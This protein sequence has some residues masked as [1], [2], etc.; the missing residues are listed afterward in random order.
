MTPDAAERLEVERVSRYRVSG[1]RSAPHPDG[2]W[3]PWS[4]ANNLLHR[5]R[6]AESEVQRLRAEVEALVPLARLG[7][8]TLDVLIPG[9]DGHI[10]NTIDFDGGDVELAARELD[11]FEDVPLD[12]T[13]G[14]W[15][16]T[17]AETEA[18]KRARALL[19]GRKEKG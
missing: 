16:K 8:F 18:T 3:T 5:A 11:V 12:P 2:R 10:W 19:A 14:E 15:P 4:E 7:V 13:K 17:F 9:R 6:T 1:I